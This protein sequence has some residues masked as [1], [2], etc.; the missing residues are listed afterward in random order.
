MLIFSSFH[1]RC[2]FSTSGVTKIG[3]T[4]GRQLIVSPIFFLKKLTIFFSH[5]PVQSD[6]FLAVVS[7]PLPPSDV[8]YPVFFLNSATKINFS[9]VSPLDGVTRGGP[10]PPFP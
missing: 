4:R 7:S 2:E 9:R 1:P 8:V 5:R 10:P 6:D 3:V